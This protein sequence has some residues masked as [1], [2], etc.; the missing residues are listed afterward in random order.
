MNCKCNCEPKVRW[1]AP[2]KEGEK[3]YWH[4]IFYC[5]NPNCTNYK[6]DIGTRKINIFDESEIIE[7]SSL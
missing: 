6:K 5:D 3:S 1:G 7:E 4:Q 2:L